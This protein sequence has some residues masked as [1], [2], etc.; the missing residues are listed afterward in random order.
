M[1]CQRQKDR[2]AAA[3]R[4]R[5]GTEEGGRSPGW[6]NQDES[7]GSLVPFFSFLFLF[8]TP[9]FVD[10]PLWPRIRFV[11]LS[12]SHVAQGP[13][14]FVFPP[15]VRGFHCTLAAHLHTV[16]LTHKVGVKFYK[17]VCCVLLVIFHSVKGMWG[18]NT[19][20]HI[21]NG[22]SLTRITLLKP[23]T[24]TGLILICADIM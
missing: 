24:K 15:L 17:I 9:F 19:H 1:K 3:R 14:P 22:N 21:K 6:R 10:V 16:T 11:F 5:G 12:P 18:K 2:L 7:I 8:S 20:T 4:E 13:P 23:N